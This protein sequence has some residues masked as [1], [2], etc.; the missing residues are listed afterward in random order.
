MSNDEDSA[1]ILK[2]RGLY[3]TRRSEPD[4]QGLSAHFDFSK[5][6]TDWQRRV[7]TE[8][9]TIRSADEFLRFIE[10]IPRLEMDFVPSPKPSNDPLLQRP[11]IDFD[12]HMVLT[13]I[14]HEPNR[15]IDSEILALERTTAGLRILCR[16]SAPG[17]V[18][19]K[20]ISY[21]TYCAVVVG[22]FDGEVV[23][24]QESNGE[25]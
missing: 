17:P 11:A 13:I 7:A 19:S 14:S 15:F 1:I 2:F 12:R 6:R 9:L 5:P 20:I 4:P 8:T 21:G 18:V 24:E 23:F 22:R 10:R 16:F 25:R 3:D